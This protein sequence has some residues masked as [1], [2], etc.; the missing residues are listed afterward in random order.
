[1]NEQ[2]NALI[3]YNRI[4]SSYKYIEKGKLCINGWEK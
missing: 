4:K 3:E 2:L 1:M